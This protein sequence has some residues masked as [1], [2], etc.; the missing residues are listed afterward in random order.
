MT[1]KFYVQPA[2]PFGYKDLLPHISEEQLKIHYEKHHQAYVKGA[3]AIL[4]RLDKARQDGA[5]SGRRRCS[6]R[7]ISSSSV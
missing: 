7:S 6:P 3:N 5:L 4:E 2:L 1:T